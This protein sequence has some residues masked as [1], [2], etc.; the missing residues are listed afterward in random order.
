MS[1]D[2]HFSILSIGAWAASA[3]L[4]NYTNFICTYYVFTKIVFTQYNWG[5]ET[6]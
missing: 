2:I 6:E 4:I 1:K 5:N 3:P